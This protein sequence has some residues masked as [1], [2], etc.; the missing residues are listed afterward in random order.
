MKNNQIE[1][2]D[3]LVHPASPVYHRS[4]DRRVLVGNR[5]VK[6][7]VVCDILAKHINIHG[8]SDVVAA[9]AHN[10]RRIA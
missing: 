2:A 7:S 4:F 5:W 9:L 10:A 6:T 3:S 8:V 1:I